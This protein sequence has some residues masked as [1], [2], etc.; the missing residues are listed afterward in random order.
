MAPS[1]SWLR[2]H[3]PLGP[4]GEVVIYKKT[5]I[6]I[7][8]S[9]VKPLAWIGSSRKDLRK[10]PKQVRTDFGK[11]LFA[12]QC[13]TTDPAAKPLKG[14]GGAGVLEIVERYDTNTYRAVYV[15][16]FEG[17]VYVLHVFQKKAKAG[18]ATPKTDIELI[19]KRLAEAER[20]FRKGYDTHGQETEGN[21]GDR[22]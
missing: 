6:D 18:A 7:A 11:A 4:D 19:R 16:Q 17:I 22:E 14:F 8:A 21:H 13:G 20:Q 1:S 9:V 10:L 15:V 2:S 3:E 5:Y 12:A